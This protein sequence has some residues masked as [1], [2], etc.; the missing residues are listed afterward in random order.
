MD[1]TQHA[2][3]NT[4]SPSHDIRFDPSGSVEDPSKKNSGPIY[5]NDPFLQDELPIN[6]SKSICDKHSK[7]YEIFKDFKCYP[8]SAELV[9][10]EENRHNIFSE[11]DIPVKLDNK[12]KNESNSTKRNKDKRNHLT[13]SVVVEFDETQE[14]RESI[15]EV[16]ELPQ[17]STAL[18]TYMD[19]SCSENDSSEKCSVDEFRSSPEIPYSSY[20]NFWRTRLIFPPLRRS[21][22]EAHLLHPQN[23]RSRIRSYLQ[24]AAKFLRLNMGSR[25]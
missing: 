15:F 20:Q 17:Q 1:N 5:S 19:P 12:N 14:N 11:C 22:S 23:H 9:D 7:Y 3:I 24:T 10:E 16:C 13:P 6:Q 18:N 2:R 4:P 8:I 25:N 21:I